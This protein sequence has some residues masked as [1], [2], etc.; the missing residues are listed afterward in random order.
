[1]PEILTYDTEKVYIYIGNVEG[2][3]DTCASKTV[4]HPHFLA[5]YY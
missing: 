4:Y 1:M 3:V 2:K 5:L